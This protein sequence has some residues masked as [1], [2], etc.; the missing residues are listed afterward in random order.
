MLR[1]LHIKQKAQNVHAP[2]CLI[3]GSCFVW[4]RGLMAFAPLRYFSAR[5]LEAPAPR[6]PEPLPWGPS[7]SGSP[8]S[9][10]RISESGLQ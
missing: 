1:L 7:I 2:L 9:S 3:A 4:R 10:A 8:G 5:Y 6:A